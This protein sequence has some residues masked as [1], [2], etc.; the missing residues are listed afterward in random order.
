MQAA[1]ITIKGIDLNSFD[2]WSH[3]VARGEG[4][5]GLSTMFFPIHRVARVNLDETVGRV[6]ALA[7]VFAERVGRDVW[8]YLGLDAGG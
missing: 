6:P 5:M 1:G 2:D 3:S 7:D 4:D 8:S